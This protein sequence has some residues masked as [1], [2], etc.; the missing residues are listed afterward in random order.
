MNSKPTG[1][2]GI[3][4]TL[5]IATDLHQSRLHYQKLAQAVAQYRPDVVALV[6][7]VLDALQ[8][9]TKTQF[10]TKECAQ[11]LAALSV[12]HLIF[13]RGNHEDFTWPE[14]V[15][16]WPHERRPLLALYG[17]A[18]AIGPLVIVGFPCMVGSEFHWCAH[19]P[20]VG[21]QVELHPLKSRRPLPSDFAAW[22][23]ALMRKTGPVGRALW[24]M[25]ESPVGLPLAKP[26]VFN[27]AW[28]DAVERFGPLIVASGHDH[29]TPLENNTW[30]AK[31]GQTVCVNAGQRALEFHYTIMDFEFAGAEP[32]LPMRIR[33]RA[34]PWSEELMIQPH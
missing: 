2:G 6:G 11:Q 17:T 29:D 24:L 33:V 7:D 5:L 16:A 27:A 23:P 8:F 3:H 31:L 10:T 21:N 32:S 15:A 26:Q 1:I 12:E 14:F 25:H 18:C 30:H 4:I 20:T 9:S 34:I 22:L 19:L 13:I 28:A